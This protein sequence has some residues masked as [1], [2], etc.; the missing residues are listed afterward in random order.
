MWHRVEQSMSRE[1]CEKREKWKKK[2]FFSSS[3]VQSQLTT[4]D[5]WKKYVITC[6]AG[7][8]YSFW[9]TFHF[10]ICETWEEWV[11]RLFLAYVARID[12]TEKFFQYFEFHSTYFDEIRKEQMWGGASEFHIYGIKWTKLWKLT[13]RNW[14]FFV[15]LLLLAINVNLVILDSIG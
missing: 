7:K 15:V 4:V 11:D 12:A 1:K 9:F 3:V 5:I 14:L 13:K 2:G 10:D 8:H 6:T